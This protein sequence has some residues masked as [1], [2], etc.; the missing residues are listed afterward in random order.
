MKKLKKTKNAALPVVP[1]LSEETDFSETSEV[2]EPEQQHRVINSLV[3]NLSHALEENV[4]EI[5]EMLEDN[6][7]VKSYHD[8]EKRPM[9]YR[10]FLILG[11]LV[12]WLA[13]VGGIVTVRSIGEFVSDIANR[14]TLKEEFE[15][16]IFP[17]VIEDPPEFTSTE[18]LQ[19]RTAIA[20]AIWQIILSG[21]T[22]RF[23]R[24][25]ETGMVIVPESDVEA[26]VRGIFGA[27]FEIEHRNIDYF[28]LVFQY[29]PELKSYLVP[30][31]PSYF[32]FS[33]RVVAISNTGDT[34]RIT[35]EYIA[36]TPL[37]IAGIEHEIMPVKS[38]IYTIT[39]SRNRTKTIQ[40][41]E[42]N[43]EREILL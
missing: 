18:N 10:F 3:G 8:R 13:I 15:R 21:E 29:M 32:T 19:S 28:V 37:L 24:D 4:A 5:D 42:F 1:V 41:I 6:P 35:V 36:P 20:S 40:A 30:E 9:K 26:A 31:N 17:V 16:F 2:K 7:Q 25:R 38:M 23:E 43:R 22:A 27:G 14:T 39:R 33:P 12:F 11:L 34:Y